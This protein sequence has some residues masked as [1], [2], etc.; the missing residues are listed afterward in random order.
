MNSRVL[1]HR[2]GLLW[3]LWLVVGVVMGL[4]E[5]AVDRVS[6]GGQVA[7]WRPVLKQVLCY[8]MWWLLTPVVLL[9]GRSY[10]L[11]R[12]G[13]R[14]AGLVHFAAGIVVPVVYLALAQVFVFSWLRPRPPMTRTG[15]WFLS[16]VGNFP[17]ELLTYWA[18]LTTQQVLRT[19]QDRR[20]REVALARAEAGLADARLMA[21]KLQLEPHFLFNTLNA[22]SELIHA[23][24]DRA[25]AMVVR[26][27]DFL[28]TTLESGPRQLVTLREELAYLER[29]LAIEQLRFG[30]RL[31]VAIHVEPGAADA[32]VPALFL[33]PLVENAVRHGVARQVM[34]GRIDIS[35]TT[36]E[37]NRVALRVANTG[38]DVTLPVTFGV[39]LTNTTAR[40]SQLFGLRHRFTATPRPGGGLCVEVEM[41]CTSADVASS[42]CNAHE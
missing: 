28:R 8:Q 13:W 10:P 40:L 29:Y 15:E 38:P 16:I 12:E 20:D 37:P 1:L 26:L 6:F 42:T 5:L 4:Q 24:P 36:V 27:G 17:G 23:D 21:L 2:A 41:P 30:E 7:W 35:A 9:L 31:S 39:G 18:I 11:D 22:I 34:P 33:Q 14:R 3:A 19:Y 25:D 32:L